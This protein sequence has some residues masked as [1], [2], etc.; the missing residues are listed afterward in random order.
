MARHPDRALGQGPGGEGQNQ[1]HPG[2]Y[3]RGTSGCGGSVPTGAGWRAGA[4]AVGAVHRDK[5]VGDR[6][7]PGDAVLV[8]GRAHRRCA[9]RAR[10][11][12]R[13]PVP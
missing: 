6:V 11:R 4:G 5:P 10:R 13:G 12:G 8:A 2:P 9:G 7:V 1:V 3:R